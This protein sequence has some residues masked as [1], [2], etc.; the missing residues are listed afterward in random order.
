MRHL[1]AAQLVDVAEGAA[2]A[3]SQRHV[4]SCDAC[5]RHVTDLQTAMLA[6][7]GMD[8]PEP[9]PLFW[10]HLSSRVHDAVVVESGVRAATTQDRLTMQGARLVTWLAVR[11]AA[12]ISGVVALVAAVALLLQAGRP[13]SMPT[14]SAQAPVVAERPSDA[15][16]VGDDPSLAFVANLAGDLDWEGALEAGLTTHV[17]VDD[18]AVSQLTSGERGELRQLLRGELARAR[19]GA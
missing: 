4:R 15:A 2:T 13:A 11:P 8:A 17:G 18:D 3:S 14:P 19:G 1:T 12:I 6:V 7:A 9:S 5:Q 10:D 16:S